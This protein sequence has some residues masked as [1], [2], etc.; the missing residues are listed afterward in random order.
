MARKAFALVALLLLVAAGSLAFAEGPV[1]RWDAGISGGSVAFSG[2]GGLF[3]YTDSTQHTGTPHLV[4]TNETPA[5]PA[6][7]PTVEPN[8][9]KK[10]AFLNNWEAV[11]ALGPSLYT[12]GVGFCVTAGVM[13][14]VGGM[15]PFDNALKDIVFDFLF[16]FDGVKTDAVSM[17]PL[18]A[19]LGLGYQF[20]LEDFIV[21]QPWYLKLRII[22]HIKNGLVFV[23]VDRLD[24]IVYS[25]T[26][27][28]LSPGVS[29]DIPFP[30]LEAVRLG[31][32][33]DYNNYLCAESFSNLN[34]GITGSWA[35]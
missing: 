32:K 3:Q 5:V 21:E 28:Y 13:N 30:K 29:V 34:I 14:T 2:A 31:V 35:F 12:G 20:F 15:Y 6:D 18:G 11:L 33:L 8:P 10:S 7:T 1:T 22:P 24:R 9:S 26:A 23:D 27:W 17:A 16:V 19:S 4:L 25:G